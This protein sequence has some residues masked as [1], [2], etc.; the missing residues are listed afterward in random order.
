MTQSLKECDL[1]IEPVACESGYFMMA[2][3]SKC[4]SLIPKRFTDSHD[5]EEEGEQKIKKNIYYTNEGKVPLDLAFCRWLAVE[6]KVIMMPCS[7]F[8]CKDSPFRNDQ[9]ARLGIC[10]GMEHT[11]KA[12]QR[13]KSK[14]I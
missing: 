12:M 2:D 6:R 14:L 3:I 9:Y 5:F 1:P 10:K 11:I 8:Y 13:L 4:R 7:L